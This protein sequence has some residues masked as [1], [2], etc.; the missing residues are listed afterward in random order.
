[1]NLDQIP[2]SSVWRVARVRAATAEGEAH[3]ERV[4]QLEAK[5]IMKLRLMSN[6]QQAA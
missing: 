2:L 6:M 5:A 1:M 3:G 4:R